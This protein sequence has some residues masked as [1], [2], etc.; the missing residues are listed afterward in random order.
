MDRAA[1]HLMHPKC[2]RATDWRE[3]SVYF[4]GFFCLSLF[5]IKINIEFPRFNAMLWWDGQGILSQIRQDSMPTGRT[6]LS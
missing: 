6:S 4:S 2:G 3:I 5:P 1:T